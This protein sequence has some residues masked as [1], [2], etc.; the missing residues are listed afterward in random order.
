MRKLFALLIS[1]VLLFGL[2]ACGAESTVT[3]NMVADSYAPNYKGEIG[4]EM[5]SSMEAPQEASPLTENRK[6]IQR[7]RM[8][9]ETEDMDQTLSQVN[10]RINELGGYIEA[11]EIYN[12]SSYNNSSRYRS[13][14]LTVRIP[15]ENLETFLNKLTEISNVVSSNKTTEDITLSYISTESRLEA[16][17]TEQARLLELLS[18][19]QSMDDLLTIEAR[20][21]DVRAEL[22]AVNST[23][24]L[25]DNQVDYATVYLNMDEVR[26]Y[27]PVAEPEN[28]WQEMGEGFMESL[29]DIGEG[30][31]D[32]FVGFVISIPYLVLLGAIAAAVIFLILSVKKK[33]KAKKAQNSRQI[34]P[35]DSNSDQS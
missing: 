3:S 30:L 19:A 22:E 2:T 9:V 26:E 25:Y 24:R 16:L 33:K 8:N 12:G 1:V 17:E 15:V 20:L 23:L 27:T 14:N 18:Q 5:D 32:F 35:A 6:L 29:E 21:T 34:P 11:Q 31:Q 28:I 13:A 10:T 4:I 7:V